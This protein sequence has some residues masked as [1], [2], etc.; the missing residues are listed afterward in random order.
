MKFRVK[1]GLT[2]LPKP[3]LDPP[4]CM[5]NGCIEQRKEIL[6]KSRNHRTVHIPSKS[7]DKAFVK[8][9]QLEF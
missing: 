3:A 5:L 6:R 2:E 7:L 9:T 1:R 4:L 8:Y